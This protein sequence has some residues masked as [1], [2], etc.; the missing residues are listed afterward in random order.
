M[1]R[2][3]DPGCGL[4][5]R[6]NSRFC[7]RCGRPLGGASQSPAIGE[8]GWSI[9]RSGRLMHG[10]AYRILEPLGKG[11]M[12][13]LYLAADTAAFDRK[14]V[15]KELIDYYNP[16]DPEETRQAQARFEAEARLLAELNHPG[17]PRIY[18]YFSEAGRHYIV[19]EYVEGDIVEQG[20]THVDAAGRTVP[21]RPLPPEVVIRHAIRVCRVLEHLA[22]RP[23]PVIHHDIKPAN[24]IVER[25]SGEVRLVDFGTARIHTRRLLPGE[26]PAIF[27]TRGY[28][29]PEQYQGSSD[30]R[31]DVYSLA[32]AV[33]HLLTD[34]DP[35]DHPFQFPKLDT[36]P[37]ALADVLGRALRLEG[38]RRSTA[39]EFR[40]GLEAWLIPE[41]AS[42]P[43]V[44]RSGGV[45]H[46]TEDL[47]ALADRYWADARAHLA[48]GDFQRWFRERNRHDLAAKAESAR[49]EAGE[50]AD[51]ALEGL[52]QRLNPRLP[53][54]HPAIEPLAL[55]L[56]VGRTRPVTA[57]L[58]VRNQGRGYAQAALSAS[59][60]WLRFEPAE[61][62]CL[63][64]QEA[65]VTVS[66]DASRLPFR[67]DHQAVIACTPSRG[68][69]MSVAV[70]AEFSLAWE[71]LRR[72][73]E[74]LRVL[75]R[76]AGQGFKQGW[77]LWQRTIGSLAKS[78][79]G[80]AILV[81]ETILLDVLLVALWRLWY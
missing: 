5:N 40:Q 45:A 56:K 79:T 24:L 36:L 66:L 58:T 25:A 4:V 44:F 34:D 80:L 39:F 32:A 27:G 81:A 15:I 74:G 65:R 9:L 50:D 55:D 28:A 26:Q 11:G 75:A 35:G 12:G 42:R 62:G 37:A 10:G 64:N 68:A 31:S 43:F 78:R 72:I 49:L 46:T 19:M 38:N 47:V 2:C 70:S 53:P 52:M 7:A 54:P 51:A 23:T 57:Q 69:R 21:A 63:A 60:P 8:S 33:Y 14:C 20:V 59:V 6:P 1:L 29:A 48:A 3:P 30:P 41:G 61:V 73:Q 16:A 71:I 17:I 67:H 76:R 77:S 13:A 18:T 22:D